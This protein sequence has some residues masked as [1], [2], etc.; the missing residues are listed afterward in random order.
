[1]PKFRKLNLTTNFMKQS[2]LL[3]V[4]I[5]MLA[6]TCSTEP[7]ATEKPIAE[8]GSRI[9]RETAE[10]LI[11]KASAPQRTQKFYVYGRKML[12]TILN[13]E[14]TEGILILN[15]LDEAGETKLIFRPADENG[16]VVM[17]SETYDDGRVC[18]PNC[19]NIG[20]ASVGQVI[21]KS[22]AEERIRSFRSVNAN[23]AYSFLFGKNVFK[24]LLA[25][26]DVAGIA[27]INGVKASGQE[28]LVL[29]GVDENGEVMWDKD[30]YDD[31]R[32]CPPNCSD[33]GN[34]GI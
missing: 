32:V 15:S 33:L 14:G 26:K 29:V 6:F 19:S 18:P 3:P 7:S 2:K 11:G 30:T 25:Q 24:E 20:I 9:S 10:A 16:D 5:A 1:M 12:E 31:G 34:D 22:K 28:A 17:N 23:S 27:F 21:E 4:V 13:V 8:I